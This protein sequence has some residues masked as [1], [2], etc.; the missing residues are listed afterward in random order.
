MN[1]LLKWSKKDF[2]KDGTKTAYLVSSHKISSQYDFDA[3]GYWLQILPSK[4]SRSYSYQPILNDKFF[5]EFLPVTKYGNTHLN[6]MT[7]PNNYS[8]NI[9]LKMDA[10][11]AEALLNKKK[12]TFYSALKVK[13][14]FK[15]LSEINATS[16]QIEFTYHLLSPII[17]IFEDIALTKKIG[18]INLEKVAYQK[19]K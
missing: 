7:D 11:T 9:L 14:I 16:P 18:E 17:E 6:R 12:Q 5:R 19:K 2:F 3:Q 15:K 8:P 1:Q 10:K 4:P 13:I